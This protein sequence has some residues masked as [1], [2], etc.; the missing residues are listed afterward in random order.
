[1]NVVS[2]DSCTKFREDSKYDNMLPPSG[3]F[4]KCLDIQFP[5][6]VYAGDREMYGLGGHS[7]PYYTALLFYTISLGFRLTKI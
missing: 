4:I 3:H 1:M 5:D 7:M 2:Q 6:A